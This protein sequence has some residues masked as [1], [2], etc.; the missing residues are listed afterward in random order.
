MAIFSQASKD[1]T[2]LVGAPEEN[3]VYNFNIQL[4]TYNTSTASI[5]L[6][7]QEYTRFKNKFLEISITDD[8]LD[9]TNIP[10]AVD[11]IIKKIN[12]AKNKI[13]KIFFINSL[14]HI[15]DN[16]FEMLQ[17][18]TYNDFF[19]NYIGYDVSTYLY[20]DLVQKIKQDFISVGG[21]QLCRWLNLY[22]PLLSLQM[23]KGTDNQHPGTKSHKLFAE[24]LNE[25]LD[26][27]DRL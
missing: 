21:P 18:S 7:T 26:K 1:K 24:L 16:F 8:T 2:L 15:P 6:A 17:T 10:N 3:K 19:R 22:Q 14:L 23:D 11:K 4:G 13:T 20:E 12:L 5:N 27:I 9:L 25:R